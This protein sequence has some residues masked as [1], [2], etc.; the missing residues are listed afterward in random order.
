M[1][2]RKYIRGYPVFNSLLKEC[3]NMEAGKVLEKLR[4]VMP[5]I[6]KE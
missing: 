2:I 4:A 5:W 3:E 6:K 1:D